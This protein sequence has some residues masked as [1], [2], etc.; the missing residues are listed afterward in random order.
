[1]IIKTI[2]PDNDD[3]E[4]KYSLVIKLTKDIER[5]NYLFVGEWKCGEKSWT[6]TGC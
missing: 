2:E 1:M 6:V 3:E 5:N 4:K